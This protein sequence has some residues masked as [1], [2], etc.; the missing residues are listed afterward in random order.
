MDVDPDQTGVIFGSD[1]IT[2]LPGEF[3]TA[4]AK[5]L[6]DEGQFEFARWGHDGIPQISPLWLLKYLPNMPA[7]H[8]A[9]YNDLR[10]P[11]NSITVREAS[12]NMALAESLATLQRWPVQ[13]LLAGATGSRLHPLR[14]LHIVLQ[15]VVDGLRGSADSQSDLPP[16]PRPFDQ[17]RRGMVLGEGAAVVVLEKES[18]IRDRSVTPW[19][20]LLGCGSSAVGDRQGRPDRCRALVNAMRAALAA[21]Q[22]SPED[23]GHVHAHGLGTVTADR[24]E[25]AALCQVFGERRS[26]VPVVAAK[27][28]FGNLGA[29]SG[30]VELV[31]SLVALRRGTLFPILNLEQ[32]DTDCF[33]QPDKVQLVTT[34]DV[35]AGETVLNLSVNPQGQASAA[36]VALK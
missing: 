29:G 28:Y 17:R 21:A 27:S 12:A 1:Y 3:E 15:E 24:E 8:V 31:A 32:I 23:I 5:C 9:I 22:L 11:N 34:S 6:S 7:C 16:A 13:R 19:G 18:W 20:A 2:T 14:S 36:I 4:V 26:P 35:P 30:M 33:P 10:G 25:G